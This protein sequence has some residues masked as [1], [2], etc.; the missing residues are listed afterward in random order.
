MNF[1]IFI[2]LFAFSQDVPLK[3]SDEF[4]ITLDYAF[5]HHPPVDRNPAFRSQSVRNYGYPASASLLPYL[6]LSVKLCTLQHASM[7]MLV[8]SNLDSRKLYRKVAEEE[9]VALDL[10]FTDDM[11]DRVSAHRYTITFLTLD[12]RPVSKI[13]ISVEED[14]SFLVNGEKRGRF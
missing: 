6:V 9:V 7:R 13:V 10:G 5:R 11:V 1:C 2:L 14:G 12:K 4:E 8:S 3:P